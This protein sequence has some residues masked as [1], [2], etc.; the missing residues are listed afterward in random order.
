MKKVVWGVTAVV[1]GLVVVN[2]SC[3]PVV[4]PT[5]A[6]AVKTASNAQKLEEDWDAFVKK[7]VNAE[8]LVDYQ[9][10][11]ANSGELESIYGQVARFSPE[12]APELFATKEDKFAY[13]LN[14]Y[15]I[16]AIRGVNGHYPI[17]S[18]LDVKPFSVFSLV[19]KGGF[20]VGQKFVFGGQNLNLFKVENGVIRKGFVDPRLHFA[21]NCASGSCPPL[22]R[23]AYQG[24]RLDEQL[25]RQTR[26]FINSSRGFQI[27]EA[28]KKIELSEIFNWYRED[29][30]EEVNEAGNAKGDILDYLEK[31][32]DE[33]KL[34]ALKGARQQGYEVIYQP[35][36][37]SLNDSGA[38][39]VAP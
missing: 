1:V 16:A 7:Y 25:E 3:G 27:D 20:F 23:E 24:K 34:T 39:P 21:L 15:N 26:S 5:G 12:S 13:W 9:A 14:A 22:A 36:D 18:V 38:K 30:V 2:I 10:I 32:L 37:W 6:Q 33:D 31:Y 35:Y 29:F 4:R 19:K 8:G 17:E 28:G 11:K